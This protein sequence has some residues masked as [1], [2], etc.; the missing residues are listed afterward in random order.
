MK[1]AFAYLR[2]SGRGQLE[3]DGFPRQRALLA[4]TQPLRDSATEC[5]RPQ[6]S[7][8]GGLVF[9]DGCPDHEARSQ[10]PCI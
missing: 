9:S 5:R 6:A 7:L 8:Q 1:K 3:G 4:R 10:K 2:V